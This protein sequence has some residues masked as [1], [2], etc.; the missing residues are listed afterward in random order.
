MKHF[1]GCL[2]Q[3]SPDDTGLFI[4][5]TLML[6]NHGEPS[7]LLTYNPCSAEQPAKRLILFA[8]LMLTNPDI[9]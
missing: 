1:G 2:T 5:Y 7:T 6:V 9:A 3:H 8:F 4:W